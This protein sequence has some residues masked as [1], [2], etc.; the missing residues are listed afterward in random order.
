M[1]DS[2]LPRELIDAVTDNLHEDHDGDAL[3]ACSLVCSSWLPSSQRHIFRRVTLALDGDDC[4]RLDQALLSSP[5]LANY[6]RELK[7]HL[8]DISWIIAYG[9]I[10][11]SLA[12]AVLHRLSKLQSIEVRDLDWWRMTPD[13]HQ[14]LRWLLLLPSIKFLTLGISG[15]QDQFNVHSWQHQPSLMREAQEENGEGSKVERRYL[16]R[17]D[18]DLAFEANCHSYVDW[19]LGPRSGFEAH[20]QTLR[21]DNLRLN[22]EKA[23][24]RLL[25]TI[26]NSLQHL[27]FYVPLLNDGLLEP[28]FDIRLEF[29]SNIRFLRLTNM[30]V[31]AADGVMSPKSFGVI[32]LLRLLSN[33]DN[34]N[35]LEQVRFEII[36][37]FDYGEACSASGWGPVDCL[38]AGKLRN[39]QKLDIQ[40]WST[41]GERDDSFAHRGSEI[42][43]CMLDAC[44]LLVERG[45][46]VDVQGDW[47]R[48]DKD[49]DIF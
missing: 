2:S 21:V 29:N 33:I 13:L 25:R 4:E 9:D 8:R 7:V 5:H 17:L 16:S 49:L 39:L 26:G 30:H 44:P 40:L 38:L 36:I 11:Q 14:A 48:W 47:L 27:E 42:R 31:L 35:K 19:F 10:D 32:W 45:V 3:L 46:S 15:Y 23:F 34:S 24:N 43:Q 18:L 22:D 37:C 28:L 12:A 1:R 41:T 6:I 20:I